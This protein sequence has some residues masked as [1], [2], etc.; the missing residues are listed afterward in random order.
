[1]K[2]TQQTISDWANATFGVPTTD[3][4]IGWRANGELNELIN[5]LRDDDA[6]PKAVEEAADVIIVLMRLFQRRGVQFWDEVEKKMKVN[7]GRKWTR[8]GDG[9]GQHVKEQ[10]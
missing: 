4:S 6:N 9:H 2:E 3:A 8:T 10:R 5:A 7:R 1:M